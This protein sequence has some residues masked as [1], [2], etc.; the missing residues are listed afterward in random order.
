MMLEEL[1]G[2]T[3]RGSTVKRVQGI[4]NKPCKRFQVL[5]ITV[6][7]LILDNTPI[8]EY[9]TFSLSIKNN[10]LDLKAIYETMIINIDLSHPISYNF[11]D[12]R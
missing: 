9:R 10:S 7:A 1:L 3:H 5:S 6:S 8:I 12:L 2:E 4:L 11:L